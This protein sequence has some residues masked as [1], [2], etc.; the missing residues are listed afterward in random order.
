MS[1][2][3]KLQ[4]KMFNDLIGQNYN[5]DYLENA[6]RMQVYTQG[7]Y[8][9]VLS[10]LGNDFEL[11]QWILGKEK[12]ESLV[13]DFIT[14]HPSQE[15]NIN[16]LGKSFSQYIIRHVITQEHPFLPELAD[17]EWSLGYS[18]MLEKKQPADFSQLQ[19]VS[20]EKWMD[21]RFE[22]QP[23]LL[24]MQSKWAFQE[25]HKKFSEKKSFSMDM[26]ESKPSYFI[27]YQKEDGSYAS[28]IEANEYKTLSLLIEKS[29]L[30]D[31]L[32]TMESEEMVQSVFSWF[33]KW[34]EKE[35]IT[36]VHFESHESN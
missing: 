22:F 4:E 13:N 9:R 32:E 33:Q 24:L 20:M 8:I 27:F 17:Y 11:I 7:Y 10:V 5:A 35:W 14:I 31:V 21:A 12:F 28:S 18:Q 23:N 25:L 30:G 34:Q 2:L 26:L 19:S 3:K 1:W 15:Y 16:N 36:N 29:S 6:P